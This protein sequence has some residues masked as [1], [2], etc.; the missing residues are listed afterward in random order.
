MGAG[1]VEQAGEV[2][3]ARVESL[4]AVAALAVLV[5]HVF[6][7]THARQ[8][9]ESFLERLVASGWFAVY[10]FFV[11]TGYLLFW[12][13]ARRAFAS[14][15]RTDLRRY[16]LNRALRILPL[17]YVVL[18]VYMLVRADGGTLEQ[19][20]LFA[21]FSE[22]FS[23]STILTI[24]PVM[25]SLVV[26]VHFYAVLPLVAIGLERVARGSIGR[27]A[28]AVATFGVASFVLRWVTLYDDPTPNPH[29]R[30]SLPSCFMF[31]SAGML[32]ALLRLHWER[33]RP[34]GL[35]AAPAVW[36]GVAALLWVLV[37]VGERSGYLTAPASFLLVGACV[38]PLRPSRLVAALEWRP[39]ALVGVAS[40]S[41]YLWHVLIVR[42]LAERFDLPTFPALFAI[43]APASIAVA[44]ASYALVERPFL[45]LR[46][47]W[48]ER[49]VL[50]Y[51]AAAPG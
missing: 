21:T 3:S 20:V 15:P 48:G 17:Y 40:Y 31:F 35:L 10:V 36:L 46:R 39:L 7:V 12:P 29:L 51:A 45:R 49:P 22:N 23:T 27:A 2:R 6:G 47:R 34:R 38:L 44:A 16:A 4:R 8:G 13:F 41:L 14:G 26:E 24:N 9:P 28:V 18:V 1:Q 32:L 25:W 37:A 42:E 50:Q 19:W 5:G 11:L 33:E 43:A 30:Y